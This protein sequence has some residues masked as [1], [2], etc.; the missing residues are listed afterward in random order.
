MTHLLLHSLV[1]IQLL[2]ATPEETRF[3]EA[4]TKDDVAAV[5]ALLKEDPSLA[6]RAKS[7][8]G[9]SA[10]VVAAFVMT[11]GEYFY[12]PAK[13]EVLQEVIRRAPPSDLFEACLVGDLARA[14]VFLDKDP[15]AVRE[16]E[17]ANW[18]LLHAAAYSGNLEL[19][20]LL[21][22]RGA[23][24]D[25]VAKTKYKNTPLQTAM[26]MGQSAVARALIEAGADVNHK[27]WEGFTVLHDAARQ[28]DLD[29]VRFLIKRGADV[30]ARTIRG[31]TPVLSAQSH[32]HPE[33]AAELE[34]LAMKRAQ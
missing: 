6:R 8:N 20:K 10:L 26:L 31:E 2:A 7:G 24:V 27:Q 12:A 25:A 28:G 16:G 32:G 18:T 4:I 23:T 19:V 1:T 34:K 11:D 30:K 3:L 29:L 13:N 5:R 22:G 14:R 21:I 17:K 33:I 9:N 15:N